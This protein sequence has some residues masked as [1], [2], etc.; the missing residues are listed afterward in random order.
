M[1]FFTESTA[2]QCGFLGMYLVTYLNRK[3]FFGGQLI[4]KT[5]RGRD[6]LLTPDPFTFYTIWPTIYVFTFIFCVF[7][8]FSSERT[9]EL[10]DKN[11]PWTG[12]SVRMRFCCAFIINAC[13]SVANSH[14]L[15]WLTTPLMYGMLTSFISAY[16]DFNT[17]YVKSAF[18]TVTLCFGPA[19]FTSWIFCASILTALT[20]SGQFFGIRTS[21]GTSG[22]VPLCVFLLLL[23]VTLGCANVLFFGDFA[24]ALVAA[25]A[26]RGVYRRHTIPSPYRKPEAMNAT[27]GSL[28]QLGA[29]VVLAVMVVKAVMMVTV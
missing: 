6:T 14:Q 19:M 26:A 15:Y 16:S 22:N 3:G 23:I 18:E 20:D 13:W 27:L 28:A 4:E 24:W 12:L 9:D 1:T 25:H 5:S 7:Q 11:C 21:S 8:S 10:L 2:V 29:P 17:L